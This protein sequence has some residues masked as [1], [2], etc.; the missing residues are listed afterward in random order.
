MLGQ[1]SRLLSSTALAALFAT[2]LGVTAMVIAMALMTGY[3]EDLQHKLIGLQGEILA[4][5]WKTT[6][7]EQ[8]QVALRRTAEIPGVVRMG[9]VAYGE[10]SISSAGLPEGA[11]V[12][13]RG[14]EAGDPM[15]A[16]STAGDGALAAGDD[17]VPGVLLGEELARRLGARDGEV[18]RL[19][20]LQLGEGRPRFHYR[21]VRFRG[22]FTVGFS[23]FDARWLLI[24]REVLAAVRGEAGYDSVEWKLADAS[25]SDA[26]AAEIETI[27]G[28]DWLVTRWQT[29]NRDLFA[30]LALQE[31]MLFLLLG[32]IV[33]VSTFNVAAT[34]VILVRERLRDIGVLAALGLSPRGLWWVF[35]TYGLMLGGFGTVLG[36]ALGAS[37]AWVVTTFELVRFDAEIAAVY[38]IDSVPFR[39]EAGDL[40]A[41]VGFAFVVTFAAC[42]LPA[43]RAAR[44]RPAEALRDE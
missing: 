15:V 14:V 38:F 12:V 13:L 26:V 43:L 44:L 35:A 33:L 5:P 24:G 21:S 22:T 39:V 18:L 30:A 1:R 16:R 36:V 25:Q 41:I 7:F 31:W 11:S 10:G 32:L 19:V 42:S 28:P 23:E 3:T 2:T 8:S 37:V 9:R 29:L 4:S 6:G 17:G 34:L 27:L 40:A 20:I